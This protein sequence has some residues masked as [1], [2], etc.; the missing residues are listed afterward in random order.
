MVMSDDSGDV[1]CFDVWWDREG[2]RM[3]PYVSE[4]IRETFRRIARIAWLNGEYMASVGK[5]VDDIG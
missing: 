4:D 2:R 3:S 5:G 1:D